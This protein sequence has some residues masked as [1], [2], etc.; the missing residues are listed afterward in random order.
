MAQT[1]HA[2][3]GAAFTLGA[4]FGGTGV[5]TDI[6]GTSQS[7]DM[8]EL[9]IV[10]GEFYTPD[11]ETAGITY[12]K[13]KPFELKVNIVYSEETAEGYKLL[14]DA[15]VS[16]QLVSFQWAPKSGGDTYTTSAHRITK[17]QLP[18]GD[19]SSGDTIICSFS[20][21]CSSVTETL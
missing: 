19:A 2:M 8:P 7:I 13:Q 17:R 14:K 5:Y 4:Q 18:G 12:G 10:T 3:S 15:W 21:M 16:K 6:S 1:T 9:E 20:M 11:S